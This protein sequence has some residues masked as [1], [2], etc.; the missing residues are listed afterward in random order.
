[1]SADKLAQALQDLSN[2]ASVHIDAAGCDCSFRMRERGEHLAGCVHFDLSIEIN[3]ALVALAAHQ[4]QPPQEP[5]FLLDGARFKVSSAGSCGYIGGLPSELNGRWVAL[6]AADDDCHLKHAAPQQAQAPKV[7]VCDFV[8]VDDS[9][10]SSRSQ[11]DADSAELRSLCKARD[12][13]RRERGMLRAELAG[14]EAASG[15]LSAL[16]DDLRGLLAESMRV[17]KALHESATADEGPDMNAIIPA[18]AFRQ[19]VDDNAQLMHLIH[20]SPHELPVAAGWLPIETAPE[21]TVREVVVQWMDSDGVVHRDLEYRED[22]CWMRW[23]DHA[24]HVEVIGGHGVSYT[25]PYR[26]WMPLPPAATQGAK[27]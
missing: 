10:K 27:T 7:A 19:F 11:H 13:A 22:G 20:V 21:N 24:E 2:A 14:H 23:H 9:S 12:E 26:E 16:V 25:P 3:A 5:P 8:Q 4:A 1:M 6:V 18:G 17:M 15:H